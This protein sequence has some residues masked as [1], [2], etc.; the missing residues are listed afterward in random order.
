MERLID[1]YRRFREAGWPERR[2]LFER[3][4]DQGQRPRALVIGLD[5][6]WCDAGPLQRYTPRAATLRC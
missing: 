5:H 1:G 2:R 4:A 6:V 3:L